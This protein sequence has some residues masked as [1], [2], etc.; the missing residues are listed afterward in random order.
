[1][2]VENQLLQELKKDVCQFEGAD[3]ISRFEAFRER[4]RDGGYEV[5]QEKFS[6]SLMERIG[7]GYLRG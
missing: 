6:I 3:Q 2:N 1:M 5:K 7:A 4:L